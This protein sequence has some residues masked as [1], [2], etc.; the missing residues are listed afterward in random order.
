[1]PAN[2]RVEQAYT[3]SALVEITRSLVE[4]SINGFLP[5][6]H[7]R[8]NDKAPQAG[9]LSIFLDCP[10]NIRNSGRPSARNPPRP[11]R[12]RTALLQ[13]DAPPRRLSLISLSQKTEAPQ[14]GASVSLL[15]QSRNV[16]KRGQPG[17][18]RGST[19]QGFHF[20]RSHSHRRMVGRWPDR[21]PHVLCTTCL[22]LAE[23]VPWVV[24]PVKRSKMGA[25]IPT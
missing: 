10:R 22:A 1:M 15:A 24:R 4:N 14:S 11:R 8:R 21:N 18:P 6:T 25:Y 3:C 17:S 7:I 9:A 5:L 12:P 20:P 23:M 13:I 2:C 16:P 19:G